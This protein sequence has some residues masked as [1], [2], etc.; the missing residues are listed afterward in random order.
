M[1]RSAD[2]GGEEGGTKVMVGCGRRAV[3][4]GLSIGGKNRYRN[5]EIG[6]HEEFMATGCVW[7]T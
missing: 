5:K 1:E 6:E 4:G 7:W 2:G 3:V